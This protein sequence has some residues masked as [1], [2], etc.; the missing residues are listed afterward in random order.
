MAPAKYVFAVLAVLAVAHQGSAALEFSNLRNATLKCAHHIAYDAGQILGTVTLKSGKQTL[1]DQ[2]Q[3]LISETYSAIGNLD[4]TGDK[5]AVAVLFQNSPGSG[6][7]RHLLLLEDH[8]GK[9]TC[10]AAISLGDR[11]QIHSIKLAGRKIRLDLTTHGPKDPMCCPHARQTWTIDAGETLHL[12]RTDNTSGTG[13]RYA[14]VIEEFA[15]SFQFTTSGDDWLGISGNARLAIWGPADDVR[16]ATLSIESNQMPLLKTFLSNTL[17]MCALELEKWSL[18]V[19][20]RTPTG[21]VMSQAI[22]RCL[23]R[24]IVLQT[25]RAPRHENIAIDAVVMSALE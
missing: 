7:W 9:P 24:Q 12:E 3:L 16:R 22:H 15:P 21:P 25:S 23:N 17:P 11:T 19:V 20:A 4:D 2:T 6:F 1:P 5:D 10:R 13:L 8:G 14:A 18:S